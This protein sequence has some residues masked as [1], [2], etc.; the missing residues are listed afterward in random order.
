MRCYATICPKS[1]CRTSLFHCRRLGALRQAS[2]EL[3]GIFP[4]FTPVSLEDVAITIVLKGVA[5]VTIRAFELFRLCRGMRV[6]L[7]P[8]KILWIAKFP[9]ATLAAIHVVPLS[10]MGLS[11]LSRWV[12]T[13]FIIC[14]GGP[15]HLN[16]CRF[17]HSL[18]QYSQVQSPV[19]CRSFFCSRSS[20]EAASAATRSCCACVPSK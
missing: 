15:T 20:V 9:S 10:V 4:T 13:W 11:V 18:R 6:I 16:A 1:P 19:V 12:S 14:C 17:A 2:T 5:F 7:V 3:P 8:S